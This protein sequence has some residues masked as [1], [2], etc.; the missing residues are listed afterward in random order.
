[1]GITLSR[2]TMCIKIVE[3]IDAKIIIFKYKHNLVRCMQIIELRLCFE[4]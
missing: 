4:K 2:F 1:M 3:N